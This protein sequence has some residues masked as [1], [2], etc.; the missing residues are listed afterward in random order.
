MLRVKLGISWSEEAAPSKRFLNKLMIDFVEVDAFQITRWRNRP[1]SDI[2]VSASKWF[3]GG[4]DLSDT[5]ERFESLKELCSAQQAVAATI[6]V[7]LSQIA[8]TNNSSILKAVLK[9]WSD[10]APCPIFFES[11]KWSV[12]LEIEFPFVADPLWQ[13]LQAG[14]LYWK[15]HGWH[16]ERWVRRYSTQEF[17]D[18][19]K[20]VE[21]F[22][23]EWLVLGHSG[24]LEQ[25]AELRRELQK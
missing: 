22:S 12:P 20:Q 1:R 16:R 21:L 3:L 18:L 19:A 2:T 11:T 24:R 7:G 25:F 23:P 9:H 8:A 14:S 5:L 17:S 10:S 13:K 15:V 6:K 4:E